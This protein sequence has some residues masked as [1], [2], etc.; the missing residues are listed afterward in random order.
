MCVIQQDVEHAVDYICK[1]N[2]M[3]H[4]FHFV[5]ALPPLFSFDKISI[6]YSQSEHERVCVCVCVYVCMYAL[7]AVRATSETGMR[8][9]CVNVS[10]PVCVSVCVCVCCDRRKNKCKH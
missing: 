8:Q 4:M 2:R 1:S 9:A 5:F 3:K 7:I 10:V 6:W